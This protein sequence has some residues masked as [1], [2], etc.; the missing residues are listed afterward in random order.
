MLF[1]DSAGK[2]M[3]EFD[4]RKYPNNLNLGCGFDKR[5]GYT[6]VDMNSFHS[7]DLVCDVLDLS[8]LPKNYYV[9]IV[10]QDIL[11]HLPRNLTK[12]ALVYSAISYFMISATQPRGRP[13]QAP[14][15]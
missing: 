13:K 9:E 10:A 14:T 4:Y 12:S 3:D 2:N 6:N 15:I 1:Q 5:P 11:E 7:P 8:V